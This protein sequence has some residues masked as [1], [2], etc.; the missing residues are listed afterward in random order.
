MLRVDTELYV[1]IPD[2]TEQR[3]LHPGVVVSVNPP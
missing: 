3:I 1:R 2:E